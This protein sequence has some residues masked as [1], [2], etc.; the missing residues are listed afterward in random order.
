MAPVSSVRRSIWPTV[1][2]ADS[3]RTA[4]ALDAALQGSSSS[5]PLLVAVLA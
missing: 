2:G 4:Y 5:G 1:A 3:T